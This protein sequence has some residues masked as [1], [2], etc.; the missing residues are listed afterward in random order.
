MKTILFMAAFSCGATT[1]AKSV[2]YVIV[3]AG[4][5]GLVVANR[6]SEDPSVTV[7]VIEPGKDERENPL[8]Y[9]LGGWLSAQGTEIDWSYELASQPGAN[10]QVLKLAQGKG[11]GGTSMIN[12]M[13]YVRGDSA[14]FD[15][16]EDLGNPG[17]NWETLLPYYKKA[18]KYTIPRVSQLAAGATYEIQYHGF[19]GHVHTGYPTTLFNTSFAPSVIE[20]WEGLSLIHNPDLNSGSVHGFSIGPQTLDAK[21]DIRWDAARA[22]Y[23]PIQARKNIKIIQ[24]TV[25]RITWASEKRGR[26]PTRPAVVASGV[27]F[28]TEDGEVE[29]LEVKREVI[30]SAGAVRS[31]LVLESSGIGNPRILESLGIDV[32]VDLPG[33]GE[34]LVEQTNHAQAFSSNL[35][36]SGAA[37]HVFVTAADLFGD[38]LATVEAATRENLTG[39]AEAIVDASSNNAL[40]VSVIETLLRIQHDLIFKH[41]VT[42]A[43]ILTFGIGQ[44]GSDPVFGSNY[45]NLLPFSRGSVHLGS[46]ED[47]NAPVIDPHF[48]LVDFDLD[49]TVA[50]GKMVRKFWTS[51]PMS[52]SVSGQIVPGSDV[53]PDDATDEQWEAFHRGSLIV[54]SHPLA[55]AAMMS[56]ELGGVVDPELRVYGTANVR[57]V[58]A[59]ILPTQ[60]SGHLTA[61]LYAI[62]ERAAEIIKKT[63]C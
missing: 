63:S 9:E 24:G 13:T 26:G 38:E 6:L 2:D 4:T 58:D 35:E 11:W 46:A 54:N 19:E 49:A 43:E 57:V 44:E 16:W 50:T 5:S 20:T 60:I 3:G 56:R 61:T 32:V 51:N 36:P 33:V 8:V 22:Y 15:S 62:A 28:V 45:W 27:E 14:Q 53:L 41:E 7:V 25:R 55:T 39:W 59:S 34:N 10:D 52:D 17:W 29:T 23:H 1:L 37:F 40:N 30:V 42:L 18:E 12:G 48:F 47:I 21:E 31:P